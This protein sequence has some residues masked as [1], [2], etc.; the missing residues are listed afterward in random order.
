MHAVVDDASS[1]VLGCDWLRDSVAPVSAYGRRVF[2][3][4]RCYRPGEEARAQERAQRIAALA[5]GAASACLDAVRDVLARTPD[6]SAAIALASMGEVLGD[7]HLLELQRF[8]EAVARTD[9]L[10]A[11]AGGVPAAGSPAVRTVAA[12]IEPGRSGKSGFYLADDFDASLA[13]HR[14]VLA[15]FQ[16]ELDAAR[17]RA[18]AS[19]AAALGRDD[20]GGDE[21]IVMRAD[22][23]GSSLPQGVRVVREAPTYLL[24]S[25][26]YDA[27]TLAA[28]ERREAAAEAAAAAEERVR[29][30][31]SSLVREHAGALNAA[32]AAL[33][34]ID[35]LTAAARYA[36]R[37]ACGVPQIVSSAQLAFEG[38]RFL[39]LEAELEAQGRAFTPIDIDLN[40][41]AV[42]TG[43][44]MGG[45]SVCLQTCGFIALCASFGLPVPARAARIGLFDD[46]AWLGIGADRQ[47]GG[48]LSSFAQE[49][50]RLQEILVRG[51]RKP[52]VLI[53]EFARTTNP[54]EGK[55]LL[56]AVIDALRDRGAIGLAATHLAG[57][58]Q[59]AGVRHF[60]VR[61]LRGIPQRPAASDLREALAALAAS[62]DYTIAEVT[63][64]QEQCSDAIAL[65]EL[66]GLDP[67]LVASAR[68][69][70]LRK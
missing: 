57:V 41:I 33:G 58:A 50:V 8:C 55:A 64:D 29:A 19:V 23:R 5:S 17:G 22:L 18:M 46:I 52:L 34:E 37:Y 42:L 27:A 16:A 14:A 3:T 60:A 59:E 26:E 25:V 65:A 44:N 31:L 20:V 10:L 61:G 40:G 38:G 35:V 63:A 21:F 56:V 66:L 70:L 47:L 28:L 49:V 7:A 68:G 1:Q 62:M 45:K 6:A 43:P 36:Q 30:R 12:A 54:T 67:A 53:D 51:A 32:A 13:R 11:G 39:P 24:C 9:E 4:L 48:L 15:Q 69:V 2:E